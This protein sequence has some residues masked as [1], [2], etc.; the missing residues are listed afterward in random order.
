M[1]IL[2]TGA[3]GFIGKNLRV[4][5]REAGHQDV[6]CISRASSPEDLERGLA[7]ADFVFH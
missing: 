7:G 4:R 5:L 6:V 3:D 1:R 2:I